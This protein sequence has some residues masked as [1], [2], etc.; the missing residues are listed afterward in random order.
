MNGALYEVEQK[1]PVDD[2]Q[3]VLVQLEERH[4]LFVSLNDSRELITALSIPSSIHKR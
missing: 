2:F 4:L 1:Y 3:Q